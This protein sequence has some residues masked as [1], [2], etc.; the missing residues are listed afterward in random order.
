MGTE[1]CLGR[2]MAS[3]DPDTN[4]SR[5]PLNDTLF[6]RLQTESKDQIRGPFDSVYAVAISEDG[7]RVRSAS[8]GGT[9]R[10]WDART[11]EQ[12]GPP[13]EGH[14]PGVICVSLSPDGRRV[15]FGS[16]DRKPRQWDMETP[17]QVGDPLE[18]HTFGVLCVSFS[19]D[20]RRVVSGAWDETVRMWNAVTH[21]QIGCP[22]MSDFHI[23][24]VLSHAREALPRVGEVLHGHSSRVRFVSKSA[25]GRRIV[26]RGGRGNTINWNCEDRA[27]VWKCAHEHGSYLRTKSKAMTPRL[28]IRS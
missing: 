23:L 27:I 3:F 20:A 16:G 13:L 6:T 1:S 24:T 28:I 10:V 11:G 26:S 19:A 8:R 17:T 21:E 2:R 25:D 12:I 15:I 5:S 18:G 14:T 4:L 7:T 9:V 22:C